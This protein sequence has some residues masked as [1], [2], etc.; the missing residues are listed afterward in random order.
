MLELGL[1]FC[2]PFSVWIGST[3]FI[4][5]FATLLLKPLISACFALFIQ[6]TLHLHSRFRLMTL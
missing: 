2:C 3:W 6:Y 4:D 1:G 5:I